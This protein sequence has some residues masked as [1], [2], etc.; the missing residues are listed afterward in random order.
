MITSQQPSSAALPAKHRPDTT[1]TSG[2]R[3]LSRANKANAMHSRPGHARMVGVARASAAAFGE[4]H[5]R[6]AQ[7]F[8]ELEEAI[9]L[10]V[11]ALTLRA[12][13]HGVVVG[14]DRAA[15]A[16]H[17]ADA[18]DEAVGR[19]LLDEL[20]HRPP[21]SLRGDHQRAVLLEAVRV[22]QVGEVLAGRAQPDLAP[23]LDRR[24]GATRRGS[25][26]DGAAP[27]ARS[28]RI[29]SRSTSAAAT[30]TCA[31]ARLPRRR[32]AHRRDTRSSRRRR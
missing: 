31:S 25:A 18:A 2:T 15:P 10:G 11:V 14:H 22:A 19:R 29:E 26:T 5:D 7:P 20:L 9:L 21:R 4:Q 3:P 12:R 13:Q 23:A 17:A 8:D 30:L 28:A 6:Q 1:P 27:P 32:R 16:V 24:Q